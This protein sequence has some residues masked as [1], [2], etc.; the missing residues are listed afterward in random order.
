MSSNSIDN[1]IFEDTDS[2]KETLIKTV[3]LF[4]GSP[5]LA[6]E[7]KRLKTTY[8]K[9]QRGLKTVFILRSNNIGRL[10]VIL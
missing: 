3:Y 6:E 7:M 8:V 5:A 9:V 10:E 1:I 2:S 4:A